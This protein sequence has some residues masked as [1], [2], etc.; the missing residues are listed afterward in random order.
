MNEGCGVTHR[1]K[2]PWQVEE[3]CG[4]GGGGGG[5]RVDR[6]QVQCD[7][8]GFREHVTNADRHTDKTLTRIPALSSTDRQ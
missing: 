7:T 2:C 6:L 4:G 1:E 8:V 3:E 5:G